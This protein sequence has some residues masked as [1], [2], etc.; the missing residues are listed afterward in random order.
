MRPDEWGNGG[1][2]RSHVPDVPD[3]LLCLKLPKIDQNL[4]KNLVLE[5]DGKKRPNMSMSCGGRSKKIIRVDLWV[6]LHNKSFRPNPISNMMYF[7]PPPPYQNPWGP[8]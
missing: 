5:P 8:R 2:F 6:Y 1:I 3:A 4:K 7:C